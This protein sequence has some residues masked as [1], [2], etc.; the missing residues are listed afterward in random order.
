MQRE[1]E[2]THPIDPITVVK[3]LHAVLSSL[4][5]LSVPVSNK[6]VAAAQGRAAPLLLNALPTTE[7][8]HVAYKLLATIRL[9]VDGQGN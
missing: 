1:P 7:D 4:R 8:H 2:K 9:L 6:R 3:V 5:N